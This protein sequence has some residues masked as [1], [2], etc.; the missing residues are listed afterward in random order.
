M[1]WPR[2]GDIVGAYYVDWPWK[3]KEKVTI[4]LDDPNHPVNAAFKGQTLEIVDEIYQFRDPYSRAK[5]H[6]LTSL[7]TTKTNMNKQLGRKDNDFAV[8]WV[9]ECGQGRVFYCSLGHREE[10]Y[11]NPKVLEHYLDGLQFALGD[12]KADATPSQK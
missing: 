4:K 11:W 1:D 7:D 9:R 5:L 12:L 2:W 10:I 6:V 8:S 3:G